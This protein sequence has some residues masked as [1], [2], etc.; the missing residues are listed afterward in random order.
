M[1]K[2]R[3]GLLLRV[4]KQASPYP[5]ALWDPRNT[6]DRPLVEMWPGKLLRLDSFGRMAFTEGQETHVHV[7]FSVLYSDADPNLEYEWSEWEVRAQAWREWARLGAIGW[8]LDDPM[9]WQYDERVFDFYLVR[10]KEHI[11]G[12]VE[13]AAFQEGSEVP[14]WT[15]VTFFN[16]DLD[17]AD[18]RF[19]VRVRLVPEVPPIV[20]SDPRHVMQIVDPRIAA[21]I[22]RA[23]PNYN[24][25]RALKG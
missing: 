16:G 18:R 20:F 11:E 9:G 21:E 7:G 3:Q 5:D 8:K 6:E 15:E 2:A 19:T 22:A 12:F 1:T 14:D 13:I 25:E 17:N 23:D 4:M 24:G 10:G